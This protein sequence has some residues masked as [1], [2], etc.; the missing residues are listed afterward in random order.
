MLRSAVGAARLPSSRLP[1][2]IANYFRCFHFFFALRAAHVMRCDSIHS[3]SSLM[4]ALISLKFIPRKEII[5]TE[6]ESGGGMLN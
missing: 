3:L 4:L 6:S 2:I 1:L 5:E